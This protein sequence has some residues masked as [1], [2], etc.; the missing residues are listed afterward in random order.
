MM[1]LVKI[2]L[3]IYMILFMSSCLM[4]YGT[5]DY[6]FIS[7][8]GAQIPIWIR[9]NTGSGNFII[10]NHGGPGGTSMYYNRFHSMQELEKSYGIVYWDQRSSGISQGNPS[11]ESLTPENFVEDLHAI[12]MFIQQMYHTENLFLYG[13]SWGGTLSLK[14]LTTGDYQED[15][16]GVIIEDGGHN[17]PL[18]MN[19]SIQRI[20]NFAKNQIDDDN[21][22]DYWTDVLHFFSAYPDPT[23]W[24]V[25]EFQ[26]Y[27]KH[28]NQ[29]NLERTYPTLKIEGDFSGPGGEDIFFSPL[30]FSMFFNPSALL[31]HMN[32]LSLDLSDQLGAIKTPVLLI[33][34]EHDYNSPVPEMADD[35]INNL[36]TETYDGP[37]P[38][39]GH[40]P[41]IENP[42]EFLYRFNNFINELIGD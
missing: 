16:K 13:T 31:P 40:N 32:I 34:G 19:T 42:D 36:L 24:G 4:Y 35:A 20:S 27:A 2:T 10:Y 9:G 12:R 41:A 18:L 33:W 1:K 30:S 6:F 21:N 7:R 15:I 28:L 14:Y 22:I 39:A 23:I 5:G 25:D 26:E 37:I 11:P 3:I 8:D 38:N 29:T 17:M